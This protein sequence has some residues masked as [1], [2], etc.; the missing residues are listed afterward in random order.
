MK[1]IKKLIWCHWC[2]VSLFLKDDIYYIVVS[3]DKVLSSA[4]ETCNGR[5]VV[6][7]LLYKTDKDGSFKDSI[8]LK[9]SSKL[10]DHT[11]FARSY[12]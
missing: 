3:Y 12:S 5:R 11:K 9:V 10:E 8:P 2:D 1:Y 7:T 4:T 6:E